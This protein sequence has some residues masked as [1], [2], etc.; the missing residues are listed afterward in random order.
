MTSDHVQQRIVLLLSDVHDAARTGNWTAVREKSE[1]VLHLNPFNHDAR[2]YWA[3]ARNGG[4]PVEEPVEARIEREMEDVKIAAAALDWQEVHNRAEAILQLDPANPEAKGYV[5]T[6]Q[7]EL[8]PKNQKRR[9]NRGAPPSIAAGP[10]PAAQA[11]AANYLYADSNFLSRTL[12][13][14]VAVL[15]LLYILAGGLY[16]YGAGVIED[17]SRGEAPVS[18]ATSFDNTATLVATVLLAGFAAGFVLL[19]I[20]VYRE[21]TNAR[22]MGL[23]TLMT[24]VVSVV[25]CVVFGTLGS[26]VV[27]RDLLHRLRG[28]LSIAGE[29]ML[30]FWLVCAIAGVA[31]NVNSIKHPADYSEWSDLLMLTSYGSIFLGVAGLFLAYAIRDGHQ[32]LMDRY[33]RPNRPTR[34]ETAPSIAA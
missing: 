32:H 26:Y 10:R 2:A 19:L 13:S 3:L 12:A 28:S 14:F 31:L 4:I 16:F 22:A 27:L 23:Q 8:A 25:I 34:S 30:V 5:R 18:D 9:R 33:L 24:P 21:S 29:A 1:Q 17:V 6:A 7:E 20:W 11:D 15:S